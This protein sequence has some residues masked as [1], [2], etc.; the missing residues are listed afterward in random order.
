MWFF[1]WWPIIIA[2]F[3][4]I[5]TLNI[6]ACA[7]SLQAI[8]EALSRWV[9]TISLSLW[10]S[11]SNFKILLPGLAFTILFWVPYWALSVVCNQWQFYRGGQGGHG[12]PKLFG[13][14]ASCIYEREIL[15]IADTC[16]FNVYSWGSSSIW[17]KF[18]SLQT[19]EHGWSWVQKRGD[20][21]ENLLK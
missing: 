2:D 9:L 16:S 11:F 18:R 10:I 15:K 7:V 1:A 21:F 14:P 12:P 4:P 17:F 5:L 20:N 8:W 13:S 19:V 3:E 6:S